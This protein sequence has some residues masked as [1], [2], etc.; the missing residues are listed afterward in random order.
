MPYISH[1]APPISTVDDLKLW[2]EDEL[3]YIE[4]GQFDT[5]VVQLQPSARSVDK[6]RDGMILY[7]D[8]TNF[9][10]GLGAG[11]YEYR[12]GAWHK[13]AEDLSSTVAANT[14]AI[15]GPTAV[16]GFTNGSNAAAG[17]IGEY[18]S[19]IV[20]V[21]AGVSI[22]D[23]VTTQI[24]SLVLTPGDW[25]LWGEVVIASPVGGSLV[26]NYTEVSLWTTS[27][28]PPSTTQYPADGVSY[29]EAVLSG[30]GDGM[31]ISL[32]PMRINITTNTTYF[33]NAYVE[34][35]ATSLKVGGAIRARRVR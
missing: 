31:T 28:A 21:A 32:S 14:A 16:T 10:P 34:Y 29:A 30:G 4:Q 2:V 3:G 12:G 1:P 7:A 33:L 13:F 35:D 22:A 27:A 18:L 24:K 23:S 15:A 25:D 20:T 26:L 11:C 6:P 5:K 8:G 19:S 17:K 9:N